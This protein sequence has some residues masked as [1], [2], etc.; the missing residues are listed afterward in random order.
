MAKEIKSYTPAATGYEYTNMP[1]DHPYR[2]MMIQSESTD[3]NP[4]EVMNQVKISEE[5]D[6]KI[7]ID[8]TGY[9]IFRKITKP[10]GQIA[11]LVTL[12]GAVTAKTLY[13]VPSYQHGIK[14]EYDG[15]AF[16]TAQSKF[17]VPTFTGD[18]IELTASVDIKALRALIN[19]YAPNF[20][21]AIPFGEQSDIND[22][23]D[24]TK[25]GHLRLT[26]QGASAVG[27]SP[28]ARICLQQIRK[29]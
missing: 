6:K 20:C 4:F 27:T 21:F 14:I 26:T 24:V 18:K 5:H 9:E 13:V 25:L 11:S 23:Y 15:T 1:T 3:K 22:W 8:M 28:A 17:A 29:Y 7:P 2:L 16:V 19:G 10:A 12:D